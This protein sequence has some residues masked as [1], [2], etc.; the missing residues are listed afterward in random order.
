MPW[1]NLRWLPAGITFAWILIGILAIPWGGLPES[2]SWSNQWLYHGTSLAC[3]ACMIVRGTFHQRLGWTLVLL[4]CLAWLCGSIYFVQLPIDVVTESMG[5][6]DLGYM[7]FYPLVGAGIL[8]MRTVPTSP[9]ASRWSRRAR[10][11]RLLDGFTVALAINA[12]GAALTFGHVSESWQQDPQGT[13][14]NLAYPVLSSLLLGVLVVILAMREW[15][16]RGHWWWLSAGILAFWLSDTAF[17]SS[18]FQGAYFLGTVIDLGWLAAFACFG[19]AAAARTKPLPKGAG[20]GW[21]QVVVPSLFA[22]VAFCVLVLTVFED[23]NHVA[24][25]LAAAAMFA[26]LIR[27]VLTL[28]DHDS[29]IAS[30]RQEARTDALTGLAN[31]RALLDDLRERTAAADEAPF[32]LALFDLDGFKRFNDVFGHPAGDTL[33]ARRGQALRDTPGIDRAYR[34]GGDEYCII[35]PAGPADDWQS[36]VRACAEALVEESS[37]YRISG[38]WGCALVPEE[39]QTSSEVMQVADRRMYACKA[40]RRSDGQ[41][42]SLKRSAPKRGSSNRVIDQGS[43]LGHDGPGLLGH[44]GPGT[45]V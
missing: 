11:I 17:A 30:V 29:L 34:L 19:C 32:V 12:I 41:G 42:I 16:A 27:Q 33:L 7:L 8:V 22:F 37:T 10:V 38:S 35:A 31:R 36:V 40:A 20:G 44:D 15:V 4:G 6:D 45:L 21:R 2:I 5:W 43:L 18:A 9:V 28:V 26:V 23:V 14:V 25:V 13:V 1:A 3:S 24:S 39:A